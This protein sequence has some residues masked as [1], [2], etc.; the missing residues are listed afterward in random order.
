MSFD[1]K[2]V[3][4]YIILKFNLKVLRQTFYFK[5]SS[6]FFNLNQGYVCNYSSQICFE[7]IV[8]YTENVQWTTYVTEPNLP[9]NNRCM[10]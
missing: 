5:T 8:S 7:N 6:L 9:Y 3:C 4:V 2:N 10:V 1:Y